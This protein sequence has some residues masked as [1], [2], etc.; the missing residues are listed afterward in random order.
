MDYCECGHKAAEHLDG[1][2]QCRGD[3]PDGEHC[4]CDAF[5][6]EPELVRDED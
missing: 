5:E 6:H 1:T 2:R 4:G 3:D